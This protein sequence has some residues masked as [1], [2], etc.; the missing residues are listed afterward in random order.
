VPERP[1]VLLSAAASADGY[2]DDA[3]PRRLVLSGPADLDRVDEVRA[4]ADAILV[5]A[6]TIRADDP[7]LL[8]RSAGRR[9]ARVAAG[10]PASPLR[11]TLTG[12]GDLDP[13]ARFFTAVPPEGG[14]GQVVYAASGAAARVRGLGTGA[15]V[16]DAGDGGQPRVLARVLADLAGRGVGRLLVEGG[17]AVLSGFLAAGLADELHLVIAPF[18]VGDGVRLTAPGAYPQDAGHP[19]RLAEVSR[20]GDDVLLRYLLG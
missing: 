9:A 15:E 19:M 14:A 1:Y 8:V 12:R 17:T 2:I 20:I 13:A 4:G 7:R 6:G 3:S 10:R 5:G 11:V 18:L 16:V